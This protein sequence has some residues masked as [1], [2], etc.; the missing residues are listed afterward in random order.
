VSGGVREAL[1]GA[2]L[3]GVLLAGCTLGPPAA[4]EAASYDFGPPGPYPADASSLAVTLLVPDLHAPAWLDGHG[5]VYRLEFDDVARPRA[6]VQSRWA[7]P[8]AALLTQRLRGRLAAVLK[9]GVV[10]RADGVGAPYA[11]RVELSEFSQSFS[12][13]DAS[14]ARVR[15]RAS[16]V[17]VGRRALI[18]QREFA[19]ERAAPSPDARG[20]AAALALAGDGV[21][22]QLVEWTVSELTARVRR[23]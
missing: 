8:P 19:V 1:A 3:L 7:A 2:V 4:R 5:I 10:S 9:G 6:Y 21:I 16:L 13:P 23:D 12:A 11:L 18:A 15:V 22:A 14:R 20:A 17:D